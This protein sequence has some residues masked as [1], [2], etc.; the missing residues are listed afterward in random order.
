MIEAARVNA[1]R[2]GL[3]I[4]FRVESATDLDE[5][6]GTYD[7]AFFSGSFQHI[8][9][10]ALRIDTLRRIARSLQ[11]GGVL[12]LSVSYRE[13]LGVFS[14]TR[15]VDLLRGLGAPIFGPG[16]VSE[17]G[18]GYLRDV[19]EASASREPI[20]YHT[21]Q[22]PADV[23]AEIEAAGLSPHETGPGWWICQKPS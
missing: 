4:D 9:G 1:R 12:M 6:P 10:R 14:R 5:P 2:A 21:F 3:T 17:R 15:L 7:G 18:D 16:R 8:P 19:S 23:A 11:P 20:F 22:R 13:P